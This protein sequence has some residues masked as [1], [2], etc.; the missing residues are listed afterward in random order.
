MKLVVGLILSAMAGLVLAGPI[1]AGAGKKKPD[2]PKRIAGIDVLL[3]IAV[4]ELDPHN[5][6][7]SFMECVVRNKSDQ[8]ITVPTKLVGGHGPSLDLV[9]TG[10]LMVYYR[11]MH[12]VRWG[13]SKKEETAKVKPGGDIVAF[14]DSLKNV[15]LLDFE[16]A[17]KPKAGGEDRYTWT[18]QA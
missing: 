16:E 2:E 18:W 9:A 4:E 3:R 15:L 1:K 5:P 17:K 13:G 6:G 12:L 10:K 14:K 11:G 8:E 7:D